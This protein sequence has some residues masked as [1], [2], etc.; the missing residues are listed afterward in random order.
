VLCGAITALAA[1]G[2]DPYDAARLGAYVHG[3][4]A[5]R[6]VERG[7][8]LGRTASDVAEALPGAL[9]ELE[10][11]RPAASGAGNTTRPAPERA[12]TAR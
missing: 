5:D 6:L 3:L 12:R 9:A 10:R 11:M 1:Q 7:G 2:L 8:T 4:A